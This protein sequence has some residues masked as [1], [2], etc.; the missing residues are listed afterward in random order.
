MVCRENKKEIAVSRAK[1]EFE[2]KRMWDWAIGLTQHVS[3]LSKDPSTKVGAAIFDDKRR[4]IS[5]GY[6][7]FA[8]GV[9]DS[10]K[11]LL[12]RET[13]YK[14][15]LHA[16]RNAIAFAT[17][18]LEG[19]TLFCTHPCCTQC[20][21]QVIQ[22]GIEHVCWPTPPSSFVERWAGDMTLSMEMFMEAGVTVHVG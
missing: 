12:D 17:T 9:E 21:A 16:E 3:L 15:I 7:G 2:E 19:A 14:M 18:S 5:V 22:M 13:K 20:A 6:N 11:R 4:L 10:P 1:F 8:R